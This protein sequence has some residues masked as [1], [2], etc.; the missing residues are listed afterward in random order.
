MHGDNARQWPAGGLHPHDQNP[1]PQ[2]ER[3]QRPRARSTSP[4]SR[5]AID[6]AAHGGP[7]RRHGP[8]GRR[9]PQGLHRLVHPARELRARAV[10]LPAPAHRCHAAPCAFAAPAPRHRTAE[11]RRPAARDPP[12]KARRR[13]LHPLPA[14]RAADARAQPR[15]HRLPGV[16][17]DHRLRPAQHVAGAG[18]GG[19]PGRNGRS[20]LQAAR[21]RHSRRAHPRDGHSGDA[22]FPNPMRRRSLA[23]PAPRRSASIPRG[24]CC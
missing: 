13:D 16:A 4:R 14:R 18:H 24:P 1:D 2:R 5:G 3:R 20:G 10:V 17:A 22:G 9:F 6:P 7:H 12:R 23:M 19:L 8:C 11:H 15:P 21:A